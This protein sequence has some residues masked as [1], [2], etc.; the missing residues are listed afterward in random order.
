MSGDCGCSLGQGEKKSEQGKSV[1]P[2]AAGKNEL[3]VLEKPKRLLKEDGSTVLIPGGD[4]SRPKKLLTLVVSHYEERLDWLE[5]ASKACR[6][7]FIYHKGDVIKTAGHYAGRTGP[8]MASIVWVP[9]PNV[10]REG[11]TIFN[12]C[13][14]MKTTPLSRDL[15]LPGGHTLFLQGSIDEHKHLVFPFWHWDRYLA[16][17][18]VGGGVSWYKNPGFIK[19]PPTVVL[20]PPTKIPFAEFYELVL[21]RPYPFANEKGILVCYC[22]CFAVSNER[23]LQH[24]E[25]FYKRMVDLLSAGKNPAVGHYFERLTLSVFGAFDPPAFTPIPE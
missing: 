21:R 15:N 3:L 7:I 20:D 16:Q 5:E 9:V 8:W 14:R 11:H 1:D 24:G 22:N 6:K 2:A 23:I 18:F 13:L 25:K 12:H 10:G 19:H 17:G 4:L